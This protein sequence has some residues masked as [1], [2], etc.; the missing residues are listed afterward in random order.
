MPDEVKYGAD[1]KVAS[2]FHGAE[3]SQEDI[4]TAQDKTRLSSTAGSGL[5]AKGKSLEGAPKMMPGESPAAFG[6]RMR[7][8]REG[9][10]QRS[11]FK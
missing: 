7:K 3:K 5:G 9:Q 11:A 8:F 2:T 6:A 10:A 1:G 4:S